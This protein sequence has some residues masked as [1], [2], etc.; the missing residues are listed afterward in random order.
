[1][2]GARGLPHIELRRTDETTTEI[3]ALAKRHGGTVGI[4]GVLADLSRQAEPVEAEGS[5]V[6]RAYALE[7]RDLWDSRWWPQGI[8]WSTDVSASEGVVVT[9]AYGKNRVGVTFGSRITV[10]DVASLRYRHVLL[11]RPILRAGRVTFRP[12]RIH[13]GGIVWY[14]PSYLHVSGARRGIYTCRMQDIIR[15]RPSRATL[16]HHYVLPIRFTYDAAAGDMTYSFLSLDRSVSPPEIVAGE[17]GMVSRPTRL[18]RYALDG[19][20]LATHTTGRSAPTLLDDR[21]LAHMQG[22]V[23]TDGTWYVT[24]SRGPDGLGQLQVGRPGSF[25]THR[26]ALPVGPEDIA[27]WPARD[28][29]WSL[30]EHPGSRCIFAM[31]RQQFDTEAATP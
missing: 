4:E 9:S 6:T 20:H 19:D 18:V 31:D 30:T 11:V 12:L 23:T 13:A 28:E 8:T 21:G 10:L 24:Q 16:G 1:M 7:G 27:Y 3:D 2:A 29:L 26:K 15:V 17:Y 22:A 14:G 25:R 5:A